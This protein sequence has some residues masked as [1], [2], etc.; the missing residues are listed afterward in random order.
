LNFARGSIVFAFC[1]WAQAEV[2]LVYQPVLFPEHYNDRIQNRYDGYPEG[3]NLVLGGI[4]FQIPPGVNNIWWSGFENNEQPEAIEVA[5]NLRFVREVHTLIN[6]GWGAGGGPYAYL[7]FF[8]SA[9][10]YYKKDLYGNVDIRDWYN[11][12]Y[13]NGINGTTTTNVFWQDNRRIDKQVISL[14]QEFARQT[15]VKMR[16]VD[17]GANG[18]Q[19]TY[20]QGLTVGVGPAPW[21]SGSID[22]LLLD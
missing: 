10:T 6:T 22:L 11:G 21:S 13:T 5:V 19:R 14:P 15:L 2:A 4:P 3:D 18:F 20:L 7:E 8:G 12:G 17:N 1:V 9:G 16:M